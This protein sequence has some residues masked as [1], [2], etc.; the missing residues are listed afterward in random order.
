MSVKGLQ[1]KVWIGGG[2]VGRVLSSF[3]LDFWNVFNFAKPLEAV[4]LVR[5]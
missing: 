4:L 1:I 5:L 2:W 3:I